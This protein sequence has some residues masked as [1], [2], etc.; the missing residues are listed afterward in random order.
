M[1]AISLLLVTNIAVMVMLSLVCTFLGVDRYLTENGLNLTSLLFMSLVMGFGGAIIS[2]FLSKTMVKKS[3]NVQ[4]INPASP[5]NETEA[6]LIK[7][8]YQFA[9]KAKIGKPEV[10]IYEGT[11]N[12]FATG[13]NKNS[14]LVAVSTGLLRGMTRDEVEAVLGHE[15][16][17]V[18]NGDMVASTLIQGVLNTFVFFLS[19]VIGYIVDS[20]LSGNNRRAGSGPGFTISVIVCQLVFGFLASI[21]VAWFSRVRE[22]RAD[23]SSAKFMGSPASM[24][25]ALKRLGGMS[26]EPLPDSIKAMGISGGKLSALFS[27]HPP[28]E[29][30]IS[31]LQGRLN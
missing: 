2:L 26:T 17:H 23:A 24:I 19:R 15:V 10:G 8:V 25:A 7:T 18:N 5:R 31:A 20:K 11:P 30:R 1:K 27:T 29:K 12:A 4:V 28:L 16:S 14:A 22:F 6:W 21:I 13:A 3:M 9:D